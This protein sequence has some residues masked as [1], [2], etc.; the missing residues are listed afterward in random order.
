[1]LEVVIRG[2][3]VVSS[4]DLF[5]I[6]LGISEGKIA[7]MGNSSHFPSSDK[8]ID[9]TDKLVIPGAI[10][11]HVHFRDPGFPEREDFESGTKAAAAGG[12][13]TVVD[14][15]NSVPTVV[16]VETLRKKAESCQKKAFTDFGLYAGAGTD[17]LPRIPELAKG[18]ALAF[19]TLMTNYPTP[20]REAEF[21]GLHL[22]MDDSI[23]DVMEAVGGTGLTHVFHCE[24]DYMIRHEVER[25]KSQ[26][27]NDPVA[28]VDSRPSFAEADAI[29]RIL[30]LSRALDSRI[31][32]AHMSTSEGVDLVRNEKKH[33]SRVSCETCV[34]YLLLTRK[35]ME[36]LGTR[37]KIQPPL[38]DAA[39]QE[40]L[41][42]GINDGTIDNICSDH[43][44]FTL[45]EKNRDIW[46]A[47]PG[48][49]DMENM[50]PLMLKAVNIGKL[51]ITKLVE[52]SSERPAK[53][54]QMYPRKGQ[55]GVGADAD[56]TLVDM[57][58][59]KVIRAEK[60]QTKGRDSTIFD[61]VSVKGWPVLTMV[62]GQTVM[63]NG[64]IIGSPGVGK[65]IVPLQNQ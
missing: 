62:R 23:I 17:A 19:K 4:R 10:D 55:L 26:G 30:I 39:T 60:M 24:T 8:Y 37:A 21:R 18:G 46:S 16:E 27:R 14:M 11:T 50:I 57:K 53:I 7:I 31:H 58:L 44:P 32:V 36:R 64:K 63:E 13:T 35:D 51:E 1:M 9:A 28:H 2:G 33:R 61:G 6:D 47:L 34:H 54:F 5:R 49:P 12:V 56:V 45:E 52:I 65:W 41:W 20:G 43:S 48:A 59:E 40:A 22:K 3:T 25:L 29:A 15:P 38:R 42:G